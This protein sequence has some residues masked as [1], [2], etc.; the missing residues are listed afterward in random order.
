MEN[1]ES[2]FENEHYYFCMGQLAGK[3]VRQPFE[4]KTKRQAIMRAR[5]E[6]K[7]RRLMRHEDSFVKGYVSSIRSG[8]FIEID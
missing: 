1:S 2:V 4:I 5:A 8:H 3:A 7:R 6:Y